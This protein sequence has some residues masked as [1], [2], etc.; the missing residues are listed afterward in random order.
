MSNSIADYLRSDSANY[1]SEVKL[2]RMFGDISELDSLVSS[3]VVEKRKGV[4]G[5]VYRIK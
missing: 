1:H 5:F 2:K 4:N 3:G